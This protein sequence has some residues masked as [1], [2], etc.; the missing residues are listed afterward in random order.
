MLRHHDDEF[1][2]NAPFERFSYIMVLW[3]SGRI[4]YFFRKQSRKQQKM[5]P[6]SASQKFGDWCYFC[7]L[8][9]PESKGHTYEVTKRCNRDAW[10]VQAFSNNTVPLQLLSTLPKYNL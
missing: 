7:L 10:T 2:I 5:V 8:C 1:R 3:I 4:L 9:Y 6:G